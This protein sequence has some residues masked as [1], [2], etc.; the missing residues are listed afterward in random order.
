MLFKFKRIL[1]QRKLNY[2][3]LKIK[4]M[5]SKIKK[6]FYKKNFILHLL[7]NIL[8]LIFYFRKIL[9]L[10]QIVEKNV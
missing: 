8:F 1:F 2:L 4:D 3:I 9:D 5:I 7:K 6:N 10:R